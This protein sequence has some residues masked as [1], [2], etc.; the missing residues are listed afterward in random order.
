MLS[1]CIIG[2]ALFRIQIVRGFSRLPIDRATI[3]ARSS[4]VIGARLEW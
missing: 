3:N 1:E 4:P 2:R